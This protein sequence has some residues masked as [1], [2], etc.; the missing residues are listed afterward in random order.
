MT[1]DGCAT[2]SAELGEELGGSAAV[3]DSWL[4]IE[5]PGAWGAGGLPESA[6]DGAVAGI[7]ASRADRVGVRIQLIRRRDRTAGDER[8]VY[9]ASSRPASPWLARLTCDTTY[10]Q[11]SQLDLEGLAAA[12]HPPAGG[13]WQPVEGPL[14]L[15]CTHA[16]RDPCCAVYGRAAAA[17]LEV[18]QRE[19][20]WET[21]HTGGHRFAPNL[22]GLPHGLAWGRLDPEAVDRAARAYVAGEIAP[23]GFRGRS[24]HDPFVQ[25]AEAA[26][27]QELGQL[28][29]DD[30]QLAGVIG[31]G[32]QRE[33]VLRTPRG[34]AEVDV[35]QR[36]TGVPRLIGCHKDEPT[37][38]GEHVVT[39]LTLRL[40][41]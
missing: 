4:L 18:T 34:V 39:A 20:F 6:V 31:E 7:L 3:T 16:R 22:I 36:P 15:V 29:L 1:H 21:S 32:S 25:A 30:V 9:F 12:D 41:A 14:L 11:L 23:E 2:W 38:P 35:A 8:S 10:G 37:D 19:R 27:R 17:V 26:V 40:D 28:G 33:V 5:E 13:D 24:A